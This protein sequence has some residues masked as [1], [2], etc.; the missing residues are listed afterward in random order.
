MTNKEKRPENEDLDFINF[1]DIHQ[2]VLDNIRQK[3]KEYVKEQYNSFEIRGI[4]SRALGIAR[5][6]IENSHIKSHFSS[7][8][9]T[10]DIDDIESAYQDQIRKAQVIHLQKFLAFEDLKVDLK[11]LIREICIDLEQQINK[12]QL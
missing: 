9:K 5:M 1:Q 11:E 3:I 10:D 8:L 12:E 7:L 4:V 6:E 2:R